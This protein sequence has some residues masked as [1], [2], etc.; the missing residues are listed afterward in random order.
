MVLTPAQRVFLPLL[1]AVP[2]LAL[3]RVFGDAHRVASAAAPAVELTVRHPARLRYKEFVPLDVVV[4]NRSA[5]SIDTVWV[6]LDSAYVDRFSEINI[7]PS[8][9]APYRVPLVG[10]PAGA[11]RRVAV[12]FRGNEYGRHAGTVRA[13]AGADT[14]L[15]P[16]RTFVF[17]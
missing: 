6:E 2:A 16:I 14:A 9:D 13:I 3:F 17:P 5:R 4:R 8:V 7:E 12:E 1:Y 11:A 15:V 10:V